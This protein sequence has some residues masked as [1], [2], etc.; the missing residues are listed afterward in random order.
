MNME[1][2]TNQRTNMLL[3]KDMSPVSRNFDCEVIVL[4]KDGEP[5]TT[6]EGD[7]IYRFLVADKTGSIILSVWGEMGKDIKSGDILRI[8]GVDNKLRQGR[9]F[10][11]TLK[12]CKLKRV[13]QDTFPFV[14]KPNMSEIEHH[15]PP[16]YR[17]NQQN[18]SNR[19]PR[20]LDNNNRSHQQRGYPNNNSNM[21]NGH[22]YNSRGRP[23]RGGYTNNRG[24]GAP[25]RYHQDLD[26]P[27]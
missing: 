15:Q 23:H 27:V 16:A 14:E 7:M 21:S 2:P 4:Q 19:I 10:I 9:L 17:S 11:S 18:Q 1:P 24:R 26:N 13:G 3:I 20:Q 25:N 6:R 8:S 5:V 12:S 22:P